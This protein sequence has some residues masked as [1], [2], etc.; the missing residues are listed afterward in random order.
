[1]ENRELTP[2]TDKTPDQI[3]EEMAQTR[4][5]LT[6]KV[7]ALENQVVGTVQTATDTLTGTVEAVKSFVSTAPGAVSDTVRNAADVV[8]EK[9][10]EVFDISGHV[11]NHPWA[12]VGTSALLGCLTGWLVFRERGSGG[13]AWATA[14]APVPGLV[15]PPAPAPSGPGVFDEVLAVVGRKLREVTENVLNTAT[16]AVNENIRHG[17]PKLVDAAAKNLTPETV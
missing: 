9:M 1:M 5:S 4:E 16:A 8:A 11:R 3:Q 14:A 6:E 12:A 7:A 10:K 17:V 13:A 2:M 15:P